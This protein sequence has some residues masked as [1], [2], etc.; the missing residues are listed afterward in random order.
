MADPFAAD[1]RTPLLSG[2]LPDGQVIVDVDCE[3]G[4]RLVEGGGAAG[5]ENPFEFLGAPALS[6]SLPLPIPIDP[7]RNRTPGMSVLDWCKAVVCLP[8]ALVRLALFG[9]ALLVGYLAT[10]VALEGWKDR[11]RPMPRWRCRIMTITRICSRCILF[12]FGYHWITRIGR[13][14][15]RE[16]APIVVCNHVSYVEPI[17][18]FSE[19]FPTI[20]ASESHDT[21]PFVGTIIRAMQVI[22]VDRF[23]PSSRKNAVNEIKRK[24]SCNEFPRVLL[25][26][27]GTTTNGRFLIS[28]QLGAFIPTLPIQPVVVRYPHVHF[29]QSWGSISLAKLMFKMFTQFHNFMEV[30]YLPIIFPDEEESATNFAKRTSHRMASALNVVQTSHAYGD[31]MLLTRASELA[32]VKIHDK[33]SNFLV[34]MAWIESSFSISTSEAMELMEQFCFMNPDSNGRVKVDDFLIAFGLGNDTRSEKIFAYIDVE[35]RRS[36]TFQQFLIGSA[37]VRKQPLFMR[38]CETAYMACCDSKSSC[39]AKEQFHDIFRAIIPTTSKDSIA[40][41]FDLFDAENNGKISRD[42]FM[43]CLWKHP[44]LVGL[45]PSLIDS[46]L[47]TVHAS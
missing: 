15:S 30:E 35:K 9:L 42:D 16:I 5:E 43:R 4:D 2:R 39:I 47:A 3:S 8:I 12:S 17:F 36:V 44:L 33:C 22:Y 10:K 28:F 24:A 31:L 38:A 11:T 25:F 34:E 18:F 45:F 32:K 41:L 37:L 6:L 14:A 40:R 29:D 21:L 7:F 26:P 1:I 13:P 20:V 27:E 23:S 46:S 19:L